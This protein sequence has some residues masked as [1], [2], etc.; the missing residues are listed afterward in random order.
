MPAP[1]RLPRL[2]ML[3]AALLGACSIAHEPAASPPASLGVVP[4]RP[5]VMV[6]PTA[7]VTGTPAPSPTP[8]ASRDILIQYDVEPTEFR[9]ETF[10]PFGRVPPFTLLADG[11][12]LYVDEG[13]PP[14]NGEQVMEVRLSAADASTLVGQVLARG[15]DR[16]QTD[17]DQ[18][19]ASGECVS[20]AASTILRVRAPGAPLREVRIYH[21]FGPDP[22]ALRAVR[23]LLADY[24]HPAARPYVPAQ[25]ALVVAPVTWPIAVPV[26]DWP[27]GGAWLQPPAAGLGQWAH[28]LQGE[29]LT[30][31]LAQSPRNMGQA[32]YRHAGQLYTTTL[33][34]WLPGRDD[35]AGVAAYRQVAL[36]EAI[37]QPATSAAPILT[38]I[39]ARGPC[40]PPDPPVAPQE[41]FP[42]VP[43]ILAR[44]T[45]FPP[46][47]VVAL[48]VKRDSGHV[49]AETASATVGADGTF[50]VRLPLLCEP[51]AAPGARSIVF[52]RPPRTSE[53]LQ[54]GIIYATAD[55]TL[56]PSAPSLPRLP[57]AGAGG[58]QEL[59]DR[60]LDHAD[61]R[62]RGGGDG[63]RERDALHADGSAPARDILLPGAGGQ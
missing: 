15:W 19:R 42:Q 44:G 41:G 9:P 4:G 43:R 18:C 54:Q 10:Y 13:T 48:S 55:F 28:V 52:A 7:A 50:A 1:Y 36:P 3:V 29:V 46:G 8:L 61:H 30:A 31:F 40:T 11:R 6:A 62:L 14:E 21:D 2:L 23:S 25:A 12:L 32:V 16:L 37:P 26:R 38:L 39:P 17:T 53:L 34:P 56:D 47:Q 35:T 51:T 60:A 5:T 63:G 59:P 58:A 24:R 33:V 22:E 57:A 45:H 27:L 20:D 49:I